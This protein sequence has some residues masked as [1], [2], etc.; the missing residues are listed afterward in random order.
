MM[1][2]DADKDG[3][4]SQREVTDARLQP[5]FQRVDAD[6]NGIVTKEELEA[7]HAK[8]SATLGSDRRG[9]PPG[10][11]GSGDAGGRGRPR[12]NGPPPGNARE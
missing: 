9:P 12:P 4:L 5:L 3:R 10:P 8:E 2:F 1:S 7:F 6:K 11:G